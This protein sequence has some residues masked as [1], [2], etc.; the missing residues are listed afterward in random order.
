M[1]VVWVGWLVTAGKIYICAW[2]CVSRFIL[3]DL[4]KESLCHP[5]DRPP[6]L[7]TP[8]LKRE[9]VIIAD[10]YRYTNAV[11]ILAKRGEIEV[12]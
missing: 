3:Q 7:I 11:G 6:S 10:I 8:L 12:T 4:E 5:H 1:C 9:L 2:V